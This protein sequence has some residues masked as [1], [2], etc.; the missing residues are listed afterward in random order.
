MGLHAILSRFLASLTMSSRCVSVVVLTLIARSLVIRRSKIVPRL[1]ICPYGADV[2]CCPDAQAACR[3]TRRSQRTITM[4]L[5]DRTVYVVCAQSAALV[6]HH[7]P[8]S[9]RCTSAAA[10]VKESRAHVC[11]RTTCRA[12]I[13]CQRCHVYRSSS[14]GRFAASVDVMRGVE[15]PSACVGAVTDE[16]SCR[17]S[18]M[19]AS[20]IR[21]C[22]S[23]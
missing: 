19:H 13:E 2:A 6:C 22:R 3:R 10:L 21:C 7:G 17:S 5:H 20:G 9:C 18:Q 15:T 1:R 23:T 12:S 4:E 16:Y 8:H 14:I 11:I